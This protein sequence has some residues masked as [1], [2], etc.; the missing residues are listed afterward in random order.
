MNTIN[1]GDVAKDKIT[2]FEGVV[3]ADT[4]WLN[5]CRRLTLQ[6]QKLKDGKSLETETYDV[7]HLVLVKARAFTGQQ[8]TGGPRP[9]PTRA[10][11][12]R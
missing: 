6:P 5:G 3:V 1:L 12:P 10:R 11:D 8:K 2:G 9:S 4:A 7:T